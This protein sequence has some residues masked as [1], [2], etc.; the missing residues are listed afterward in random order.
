[1]Y[2]EKPNQNIYLFTTVK[3]MK[4]KRVKASM[5]YNG[6]GQIKSNTDDVPV[7]PLKTP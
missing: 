6:Y 1:M 2:V 7:Y 4:F 5:M 3:T